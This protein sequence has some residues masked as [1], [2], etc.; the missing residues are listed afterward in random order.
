MIRFT[1]G[2][3]NIFADLGFDNPEE[4]QRKADLVGWM[5]DVIDDRDLCTA[6]AAAVVGLSAS[7]MGKLLRGRAGDYEA[8]ELREMLASLTTDEG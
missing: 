3:G 8:A 1:R 6:D 2:S 5:Q 4:C 7:E